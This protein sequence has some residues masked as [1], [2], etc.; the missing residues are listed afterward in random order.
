MVKHD[1]GRNDVVMTSIIV[2]M[3]KKDDGREVSLEC[4][5]YCLGW[6]L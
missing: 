6:P 2:A 3:V 5:L 1:A 4:I